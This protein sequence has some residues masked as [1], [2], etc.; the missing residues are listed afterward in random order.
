MNVRTFGAPVLAIC[1]VSL[2]VFG[3]ERANPIEPDPMVDAT[4][5]QIQTQIFD[6]NCAISGCHGNSS[7]Q[8]GLDLSS[9]Q[10]F[11]STV[12]VASLERQSLVRVA[13]GDPEGSY[14][15]HKI[16]GDNTIS[17]SR[18]PLGRPALSA[19]DIDLVRQWIEDGALDN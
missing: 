13:P 4:L 10:A 1:I 19:A 7:P 9:G 12:N 18:M 16:R 5:S 17:G 14:L 8:L 2:T 6:V 11:Q 15:L 3:C